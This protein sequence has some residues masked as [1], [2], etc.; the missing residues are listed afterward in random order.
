M[1]SHHR[2][3]SVLGLPYSSH[4]RGMQEI[5]VLLW[6]FLWLQE[7]QVR[8][9]RRVVVE[10]SGLSYTSDLYIVVVG[11]ARC[12]VLVGLQVVAMFVDIDRW[13]NTVVIAV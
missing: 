3:P 2:P 7:G 5:K 13:N 9:C 10:N 4:Y 8:Q 11:Y 1:L 12:S 6:F